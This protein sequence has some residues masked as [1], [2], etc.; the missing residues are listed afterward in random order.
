MITRDNF[1]RDPECEACQKLT[2]GENAEALRIAEARVV[3][4]AMRRWA[5]GPCDAAYYGLAELDAACA[6]LRQVRG[7]K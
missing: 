1:I 2:D 5:W 7:E 3:E 6:A 4:A